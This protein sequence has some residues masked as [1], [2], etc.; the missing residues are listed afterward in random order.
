MLIDGEES[1]AAFK[2]LVRI[3]MVVALGLLAVQSYVCDCRRIARVADG[4]SRSLDSNICGDPAFPPGPQ[5][6]EVGY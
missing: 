5:F 3:Q 4:N 6:K 2:I 1:L